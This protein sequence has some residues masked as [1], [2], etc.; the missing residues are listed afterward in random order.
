MS[1]EEHRA[2]LTTGTPVPQNAGQS[3]APQVHGAG[4][5]CGKMRWPAL[6]ALVVVAAI[7]IG[8]GV[9]CGTGHCHPRSSSSGG[10]VAATPAPLVVSGSVLDSST[11]APISGVPVTS[12]LA[13]VTTGADGSFTGLQIA[14]VNGAATLTV[15]QCGAGLT[16]CNASYPTGTAT[17]A[18][19]TGVSAYHK[20]VLLSA[21]TVAT[22]N[23]AT[24]LAAV[25]V[26]GNA[27]ISIPAVPGSPA[28]A[29]SLRYGVVPAA[30]GPGA[31]RSALPGSVSNSTLLQ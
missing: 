7:A 2:A 15:N 5:G 12:S 23:A 25:S 4:G 20:N 26:G 21:L 8:V 14:S 24:G 27:Q 31:L 28:G 22:F 9:G 29:L 16:G 30:A 18:I 13:T 3:S 10:V 17:V 19:V 1:P 11:N 6:V